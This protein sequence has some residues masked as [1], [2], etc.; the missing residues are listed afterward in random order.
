MQ[1]NSFG[2]VLN[3]LRESN[4]ISK[5]KLA[6]EINVSRQLLATLESGHSVPNAEHLLALADFFD[7]TVDYL[8]G[9][10]ANADDKK[11]YITVPDELTDEERQ[12]IEDYAF[13]VLQRRNQRR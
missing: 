3:Y 11:T 8:L 12:F 5:T 2:R 9:R 13:F 10:N 4:F 1:S 7:V 6:K